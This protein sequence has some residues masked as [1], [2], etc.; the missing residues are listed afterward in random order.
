MNMNEIAQ[1]R[2]KELEKENA[3]IRMKL[4]AR[5]GRVLTIREARKANA[6]QMAIQKLEADYPVELQGA[7]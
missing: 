2:I 5:R 7:A 4:L 6:G 1:E 3:L